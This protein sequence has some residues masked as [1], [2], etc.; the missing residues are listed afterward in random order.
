[1]VPLKGRFAGGGSDF[2]G[3]LTL[4]GR[5]AGVF[6]ADARKAVWTAADGDTVTNRTVSFV[7]EEEL[8]SSVFGYEQALIIA[9]GTGRFADASGSATVVG[10]I[11]L[12]TGIYLGWVEGRISR[13]AVPSLEARSLGRP[14][15]RQ[16]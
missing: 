3:S 2:S 12:D 7:L 16:V 14:L 5:F 1:M 4:M 13:P 6:D 9:G 8:S 15:E 10:L 11:D